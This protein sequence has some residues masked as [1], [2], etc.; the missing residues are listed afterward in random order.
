[1]C[2][3]L[4]KLVTI[5]NC[6]LAA[7]STL[8]VQNCIH[9]QDSSSGIPCKSHQ[10][11]KDKSHT[12]IS[13]LKKHLNETPSSDSALHRSSNVHPEE[14]P[15]LPDKLTR[16]LYW[17]CARSSLGQVAHEASCSSEDTSKEFSFLHATSK[18]HSNT[19]F[20]LHHTK[21][22]VKVSSAKV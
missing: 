11:L 1:M 3:I 4:K 6:I 9:V 16:N 22:L 12:C 15:S 7:K 8:E 21:G 10:S 18:Q 14:I 17:V 13:K 5:S 2:G 20:M 19:E